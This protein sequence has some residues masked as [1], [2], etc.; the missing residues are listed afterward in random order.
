MNLL[1]KY[2]YELNYISSKYKY[3][4]LKFRYS[5]ILLFR[6]YQSRLYMWKKILKLDHFDDFYKGR[7]SHNLFIELAP[8]WI[9]ELIQEE[10]VFNDLQNLGFNNLIATFRQYDAFFVSMYINWEIFKDKPEIQ[11]FSEL[12]HPYEPVFKIFSRGGTI[13]NIH[14]AFEIDRQETYIKHNNNFKLPSLNEDFLDFVDSNV[15]DFPNQE[16]VNELWDEFQKLH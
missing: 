7:S 1:D 9:S 4:D 5:N 3:N 10:Q 16:L 8:N 12:P 11:I 2:K 6:E 13:S 15:S 14:S